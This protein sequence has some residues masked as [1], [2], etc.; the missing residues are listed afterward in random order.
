MLAS[1]TSATVFTEAAGVKGRLLGSRVDWKMLMGFPGTD[2]DSVL[3]SMGTS[4]SVLG[5][6]EFEDL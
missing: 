6:V 4:N 1:S 3:V 5:L 2:S